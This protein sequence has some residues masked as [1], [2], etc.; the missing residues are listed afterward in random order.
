MAKLC[1]CK[2]IRTCLLCEKEF[3]IKP[4]GPAS[5]TDPRE[6]HIYC[7]LCNLAWRGYDMNAWKTH[8]HHE[9]TPF[10]L[11]GV[12]LL[13]SIP[14]PDFLTQEEADALMEGMDALPWSTSQSGRSKQNF[15]PKC[16]FK[17]QKLKLGSFQGFPSFS[18][19]VQEKLSSVP[20][21]SNFK[22]VEQ[23]NMEYDPNRGACIE[24]HV[25]DCWVWGERV[26]TLNVIGDAVLTVTPYC[27]DRSKYN[28]NWR[29][30]YNPLTSEVKNN[31]IEKTQ[32][33]IRIPLLARSLVVLTGA[34]RYDWEHSVLREDV[35][36][37]RVC[38]A[39]REFTPW[40]LPGGRFY[41][42]VGKDV[43]Q[44]ACNF[45]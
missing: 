2:G 8:P 26:V 34:A 22:T 38:I 45:F 13:V 25:D 9:G 19:F 4:R 43:L 7:P 12:F 24:P 42:E 30:D 35:R 17:K 14:Q 32:A 39:Y 16:N 10:S 36:E 27:G 21:L 33:V 41:E 3:G 1:G 28:L 31:T 23:C 11:P 6:T 40:F 44:A 37:R 29:T 15:G 18:E 20:L 5:L